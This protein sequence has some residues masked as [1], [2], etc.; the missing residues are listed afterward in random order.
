MDYNTFYQMHAGSWAIMILLFLVAYFLYRWG[1]PKGSKIVYMIVR[2]FYIIMVA[3]GVAMLIQNAQLS[4]MIKAVL[5]IMM[6]GIMEVIMGKTKRKEQTGSFWVV[7]VIL[8]VAVVTLGY[9][10]L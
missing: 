8:A 1:K 10:K 3:S 9:L 5:A 7:F 6:I 4:Y 2:L